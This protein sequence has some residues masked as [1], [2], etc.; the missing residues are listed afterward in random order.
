MF[1][2]LKSR[3]PLYFCSAPK[4]QPRVPNSFINFESEETTL[5]GVRNQPYQAGSFSEG[6]DIQL[7]DLLACPWSFAQKPQAG[8]NAGVK[9]EAINAHNF[10]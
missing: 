6:N 1:A 5:F 8:G 2:V 4:A 7:F 9:V 10:A 3:F